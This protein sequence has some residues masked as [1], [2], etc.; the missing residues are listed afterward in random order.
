LPVLAGV[1]S[2][3]KTLLVVPKGR[4]ALDLYRQ[5]LVEAAVLLPEQMFDEKKFD[6]LLKKKVCCRKKSGLF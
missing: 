2:T 1:L 3:A 5:G 4:Q 6:K